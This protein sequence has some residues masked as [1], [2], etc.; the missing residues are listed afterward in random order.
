MNAGA[1]DNQGVA[2]GLLVEDSR[3]KHVINTSDGHHNFHMKPNGVFSMD[4]NGTLRIETTETYIRRSPSP[5]WATQSGPML[6]IGGKRHPKIA[7]DG[8]S[9]KVRNGVGVKDEHTAYFAISETPISRGKLARYFRE[10]LECE[11]ALL[12]D[13]DVSGAWVPSLGRKD[14]DH[15]L[16][17]M[18]VVLDRH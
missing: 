3:E 7:P 17:P 12:L 4:P 8:T 13:S 15:L 5:K 10:R 18:V 9:H 2:M 1:F 11:D 16:G 6:L 14:K